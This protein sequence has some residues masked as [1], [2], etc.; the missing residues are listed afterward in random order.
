MKTI[1]INFVTKEDGIE[2]KIESLMEV[3]KSK[4]Y[5][6]MIN[7]LD[8]RLKKTENPAENIKWSVGSPIVN[9]FPLPFEN[10]D[11]HNSDFVEIFES[12]PSESDIFIKIVDEVTPLD[13]FIDELELDVLDD[14]NYAACYSDFYVESNNEKVLFFQKGFPILSSALPLVAFATNKFLQNS[15]MPNGDGITLS[16]NLSH[17]VPKPLCSVE[18]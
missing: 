1:S 13:G 3:C 9:Y 7:I 2:K 8:Y 5:I 17:H 14:E 10:F 4:N 16:E 6:V 11:A 18:A 15:D 12:M